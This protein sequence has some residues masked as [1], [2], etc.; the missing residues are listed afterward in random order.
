MSNM[1]GSAL[2]VLSLAACNGRP[3]DAGDIPD[4]AI[5][6]NLAITLGGDETAAGGDEDE[7]DA[8]V[9]S[10]WL[11]IDQVEIEHEEEGWIIVSDQRRD[12]DLMA[13]R[14]GDTQRIGG[15]D[16]YEGAYD[17]MKFVITDSWV[18]ADGEEH[19]LGVDQELQFD[20]AYFVDPDTVTT[21]WVGWD[22]DTE[23]RGSGDNWNLG[24]NVDLAV[25]VAG[26][27]S[28]E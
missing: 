19:D 9:E 27:P 20:T 13:L 12:V 4:D 26:E 2:M 10:V 24:T 16:V 14:G 15:G 5:T 3:M 11:R 25:D 6:G 1:T 7:V 8:S 28:P 17:A 22:L 18:V 21:L 23:L